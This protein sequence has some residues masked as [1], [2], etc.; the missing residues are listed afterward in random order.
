VMFR[1]PPSPANKRAYLA[2]DVA[3]SFAMASL[4]MPRDP[5]W[6]WRWID[7]GLEQALFLR[8]IAA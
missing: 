1:T 7:S 5:A 8:R 4:A 6:A 2:R 3:V